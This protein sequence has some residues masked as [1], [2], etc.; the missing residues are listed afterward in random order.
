MVLRRPSKLKLRVFNPVIG[1]NLYVT[2][3][4][5]SEIEKSTRKLFLLCQLH[6]IIRKVLETMYEKLEKVR[7][8]D[9]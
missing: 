8:L 3:V 4:D 6:R 2:I 7:N 1:Q 5:C 9:F